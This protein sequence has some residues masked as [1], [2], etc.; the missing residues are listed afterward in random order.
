MHI[1]ETE[2]TKIRPLTP[3]DAEH[4]YLLNMDPEVLK[5]TGDDPFETVAAAKEFLEQYD[6]YEKYGVGRWAVI[7]KENEAFL[8]WCGLKYSQE[9][10]EYDIGFRFYRKYWNMGYA[11]ETSKAF[12]DYGLNTL[13][14]DEIVGRAMTANVASVRV[15]Q[16]I[17]MD[18]YKAF[19]FEGHHGVIYTVKRMSSYL[20]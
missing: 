20:P 18:Y 7:N 16:K 3:N 11:T 17:G 2:R 9:S 8:G 6:Q 14:L 19:D 1:L 4:F 5:Y 10:K 12:I 13:K 15:L